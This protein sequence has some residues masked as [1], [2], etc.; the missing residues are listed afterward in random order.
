[1]ALEGLPNVPPAGGADF[2]PVPDDAGELLLWALMERFER[3]ALDRYAALAPALAAAGSG[4]KRAF[5]AR[6][7]ALPT[8]P[9][10]L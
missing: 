3:L 2:V 1:M 8:D 6:L 10:A 4:A 7:D 5:V 9:A